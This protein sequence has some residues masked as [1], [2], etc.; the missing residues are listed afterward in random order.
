M[1]ESNRID[2][3]KTKIICCSCGCNEINGGCCSNENR[4]DNLDLDFIKK[5][6]KIINIDPIIKINYILKND[7][8]K[9]EKEDQIII[10]DF[11]IDIQK[12]N[13]GYNNQ[14]YFRPSFLQNEKND[15]YGSDY[16]IKEIK[17]DLKKLEGENSNGKN[18]NQFYNQSING[19]SNTFNI[20]D[21]INKK[22]NNADEK[23][24]GDNNKIKID[25]D[26]KKNK[27]NEK[28]NIDEFIGKFGN[29]SNGGFEKKNKRMY[30]STK[31]IEPNLN[32]VYRSNYSMK[33]Q[34]LL[35]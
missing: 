26:N 7:K 6:D 35:I 23:N 32:D 33:S 13:N 25:D 24:K 34:E 30:F 12:K 28:F 31:H 19:V 11:P 29:G 16:K 14:S 5:T 4:I 22:K 20:D 17:G 10:K 18:S 15:I 9:I 8:G 3:P 27:K 1:Y 2:K 21:I